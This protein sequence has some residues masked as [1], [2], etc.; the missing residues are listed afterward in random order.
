M[1]GAVE[2]ALQTP[3]MVATNPKCC[4]AHTVTGCANPRLEAP[5]VQEAP[6]AAALLCHPAPGGCWLV[7]LRERGSL[8]V[9]VSPGESF[10]SGG[11]G[12]DSALGYVPGIT[13]CGWCSAFGTWSQGMGIPCFV[14]I[15]HGQIHLDKREEKDEFRRWEAFWQY[16]QH[17]WD[18]RE[19]RVRP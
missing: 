15:T 6:S 10:P 4:C 17:C 8:L 19:V 11:M 9:S 12:L 2:K 7:S 5:R 18:V 16:Q 14:R 1:H 13:R 3:F